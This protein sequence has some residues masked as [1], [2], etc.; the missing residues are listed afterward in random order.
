MIISGVQLTNVGYIVDTK[1]GLA[2]SLQ[3]AGGS[4]SHGG[5]YLSL[6]PGITISGGAYCI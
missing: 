6:V 1:P 4:T 3:F 5:S 2:G